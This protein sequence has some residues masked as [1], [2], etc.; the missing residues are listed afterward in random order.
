MDRKLALA[1]LVAI[2]ALAGLAGLF[3]LL[4]GAGLRPLSAALIGL[5]SYWL[6]LLVGIRR[7]GWWLRPR[8][9]P[10][11]VALICLAP[12]LLLFAAAFPYL[13]RLSPPVLAV[14]ALAALLNGTLE[15]AFWRGALVPRLG[16][17]NWAG[18]AAPVLLFALWHVAP[19]MI[20][21]RLDAPGG[22]AGMILGALALGVLAMAARL[23]SGSA[24]FGAML[25]AL[26]N[27]CTFGVIAVTAATRP[28]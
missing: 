1:A 14:V 20:A 9:P 2:P 10:W 15:E 6:L 19:A 16:P 11:P 28:V 17:G 12:V 8:L 5:G 7:G 22:A 23:G 21:A 4:A 18:A 25:H 3:H 27:L 24:G 13:L 26:V